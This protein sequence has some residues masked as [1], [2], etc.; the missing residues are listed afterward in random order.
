MCYDFQHVITDDEEDVTFIVEL[1][2]FSTNT[3]ILSKEA[4]VLTIS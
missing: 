1:E 2:L 3:I 4:E